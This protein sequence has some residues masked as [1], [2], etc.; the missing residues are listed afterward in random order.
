MATEPRLVIKYSSGDE[1]AEREVELAFL[2]GAIADLSNRPILDEDGEVVPIKNREFKEI[3]RDNFRRFMR[4]KA[5][6]ARIE[7]DEEIEGRGGKIVAQLKFREME[8]FKPDRVARQIPALQELL[9][10]RE[11]L[12]ECRDRINDR[13]K[14][15][16]IFE[17]AVEKTIAGFSP[18]ESKNGQKEA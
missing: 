4:E 6:E 11:S 10:I 9:R 16:R 2:V 17:K 13:D 7:V 5:P 14:I 18:E 12:A 15:R 1:N 8:D 3:D